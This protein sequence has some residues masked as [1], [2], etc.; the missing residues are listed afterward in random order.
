MLVR[1]LLN[2]TV[3]CYLN[4]SSSFLASSPKTCVLVCVC[5]Y[6]TEGWDYKAILSVSMD[7]VGG[8]KPQSVRSVLECLDVLLLSST[9]VVSSLVLASSARKTDGAGGGASL[10]KSVANILGELI[11][12]LRI[13]LVSNSKMF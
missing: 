5:M 12:V 11:Y 9:P 7:Q 2:I 1:L 4:F 13:I 10:L 8:T 6:Q 3:Y